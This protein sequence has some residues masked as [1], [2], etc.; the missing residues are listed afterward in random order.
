MGIS[1]DL[2]RVICLIPNDYRRW[3][4]SHDLI[5][6]SSMNYYRYM[7]AE[8][9]NK[10]LGRMTITSGFLTDSGPYICKIRPYILSKES[11]RIDVVV[12]VGYRVINNYNRKELIFIK[13][14]LYECGQKVFHGA[15]T[16]NQNPEECA[17]LDQFHRYVAFWLVND[18]YYQ[19]MD[20]ERKRWEETE[21]ARREIEENTNRF[22]NSRPLR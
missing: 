11:F 3:R 10:V 8:F 7:A 13:D 2:Y 9:K 12:C 18:G 15:Y 16:S 21:R 20:K 17:W 1:N 6:D 22:L 19:E 4:V 5:P 14:G